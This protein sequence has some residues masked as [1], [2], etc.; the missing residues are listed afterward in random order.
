MANEL[1]HA[2]VGTALSKTEW[3]ATAGHIFNNQAAGDIMY[4]SSTSQL[5]RLAIGSA[6]QVLA[7]NSGASAPEWVSTVASATLAAT[8]TVIDSTDTSSFI[9]MFDSATGSLA[10]KTDAGLT[11]NAGTGMLT[12]TGFTGPLTGN[13]SGTAATVT[14]AAQPNITSLGTLTTLTVDDVNINGKVITMTGSAS[15]TAVFTAGTNGTLSI[16]TTDA[17]AAAAN[18]QITADGTVDIDSAGVLTLDSGAAINIEP[19]S[20][21]AILLD[22][23]IS[24]DAGVVTGATSITSTAF[25]GA[26]STASQTNITGVGTIT[27][28]TWT[29]TPVAQAYIADNSINLAKMAHGTDGNLIT[30]DANGA[31]AAVATGNDGQVL[32]SAGAG[33][34]PA[35]EDV[36]ASGGTMTVAAFENITVGQA[37]ALYNDSGTIKAQSIHGLSESG[38]TFDSWNY[39][40]TL[41][42]QVSGG[43]IYCA[44]IARFVH[45]FTASSSLWMRVGVWT[46]ASEQIK[47]YAPVQVISDNADP[48][49]IVWDEGEDRV[50]VVGATAGTDTKGWVFTVD[51][52][53]NTIYTAGDYAPGTAVTIHTSNPYPSRGIQLA[54]DDESTNIICF[55]HVYQDAGADVSQ[56]GFIGL[57]ETT[58]GTTNTLAIRSALQQC[59]TDTQGGSNNLMDKPQMMWNNYSTGHGMIFYEDV[60]DSSYWKAR[61]FTHDN[62]TD[63]A[64]FTFGSVIEPFGADGDG[65]IANS[66]A[67]S[68]VSTTDNWAQ[69]YVNEGAHAFSIDSSNGNFICGIY[70]YDSAKAMSTFVFVALSIS[71]TTL[72]AGTPFVPRDTTLYGLGLQDFGGA[73]D[74]NENFTGNTNVTSQRVEGHTSVNNQAAYK[75]SI[76]YDPD[77]DVHV[78]ATVINLYGLVTKK[79]GGI[80]WNRENSWVMGFGA[81]ALG[82]TGDR[83]MTEAITPDWSPVFWRRGGVST[84]GHDNLYSGSSFLNL[85][86]DTTNNIMHVF[87]PDTGAYV[88]SANDLQINRSGY[89]HWRKPSHTTQTAANTYVASNSENFVGFATAAASAGADCTIT[90]KGGINEAIT[91]ETLTVGQTYYLGDS[92]R[93]REQRMSASD[94]L[95]RAGVAIHADKI[96]VLGDKQESNT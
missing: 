51:T 54:Y 18:I 85:N 32:T 39:A 3:E 19:A 94:N 73:G 40:S 21:S 60:S 56:E 65:N 34:P 80:D 16:V 72:T 37:V 42:S 6:N 23:T 77:L 12:A 83:T 28:G 17:A 5:S 10:A 9:A 7:V 31:P 1:R 70:H 45:A 27:T 11:Y 13:A 26:L 24:V 78:F 57:L 48:R 74:W 95:Y 22:G 43:F 67:N 15:D 88:H 76:H 61:G 90:V 71:G 41:A 46:A 68:S 75:I 25:V 91:G 50:V 82:G 44:G 20:G 14:T 2:D 38:E 66:G 29:G 92:G 52:T 4:A 89:W 49:A 30:Y 35:F 87:M 63:G 8:V 47:W 59:H 84:V 93:L 79:F 96:L 36:A 53:N 62:G 86:Y 69:S 58:G 55:Y 33:Q 81:F 64:S